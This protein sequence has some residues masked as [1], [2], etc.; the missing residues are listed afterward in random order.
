MQIYILKHDARYLMANI[1]HGADCK[2]LPMA[3]IKDCLL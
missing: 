1:L 3:V 2:P